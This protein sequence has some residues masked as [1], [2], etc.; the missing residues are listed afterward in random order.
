MGNLIQSSSS[1]VDQ[2]TDEVEDEMEES[3]PRTGRTTS[4]NED[5]AEEKTG[6]VC[7]GGARCARR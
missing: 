1:S 6:V 4:A 2:A 3:V 5:R 7:A